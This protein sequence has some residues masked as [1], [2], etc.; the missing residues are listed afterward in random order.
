MLAG[1]WAGVYRSSRIKTP[2]IIN[3]QQGGKN[4]E[5]ILKFYEYFRLG[6]KI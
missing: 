4:K 1:S 3:I 2:R 6:N 5:V